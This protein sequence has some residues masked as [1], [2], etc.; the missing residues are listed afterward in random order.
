MLVSVILFI[1]TAPW[2]G[3]VQY[4]QCDYC[5]IMCVTCTLY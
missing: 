4:M 3:R 2:R 5:V 1:D